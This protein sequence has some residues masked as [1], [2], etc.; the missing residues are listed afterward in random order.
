MPFPPRPGGGPG[1]SQFAGSVTL[2]RHAAELKIRIGSVKADTR[3]PAP[4]T[5][6]LVRR[7]RAPRERWPYLPSLVLLL[8]GVALGVFAIVLLP[9][10]SSGPVPGKF[11]VVV[12]EPSAALT[13]LDIYEYRDEGETALEI[14]A[15]M[16]LYPAT[17]YFDPS[18]FLQYP[19]NN[20]PHCEKASL[21]DIYGPNGPTALTLQYDNRAS[22]GF[23]EASGTVFFSGPPLG[24]YSNDNA[25]TA[26]LPEVQLPIEIG[27]DQ[28]EQL[29]GA[30]TVHYTLAN[31][32]S[33]V[34]TSGE[35]PTSAVRRI[36]TWKLSL[37]PQGSTY[38]RGENYATVA[39]T[40]AAIN[41]AAQQHGQF[42]TFSA[43]ALVGVAGG[44]LVGALQE[45]LIAR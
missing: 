29:I 7:R 24:A 4:G 17:Q 18:V 23:L 32:S 1:L 33:Y 44:A 3:E 21:C 25:A 11:S 37:V 6:R 20:S 36:M 28:L 30:V 10:D 42:L 43:G 9:S 14:R 2:I 39:S 26:Q 8:A 35:G 22:P 40:A 12:V 5:I 38:L 19:A 34:W 31:A 15:T 16:P 41:E 27:P 45:F 13:N